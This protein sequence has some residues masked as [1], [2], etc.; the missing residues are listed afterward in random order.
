MRDSPNRPYASL[1]PNFGFGIFN[2][3]LGFRRHFQVNVWLN[4]FD[5]FCVIKPNCF[6]FGGISPPLFQIK[7]VKE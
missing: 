6:V 4:Q 1:L 5:H 2:W 3:L 7:V